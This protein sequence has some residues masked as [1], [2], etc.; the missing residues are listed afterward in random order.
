MAEFEGLPFDIRPVL[1][2]I[3]VHL[4]KNTEE[5]DSFSAFG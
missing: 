5:Y 4:T 1:S 2:P 3:L